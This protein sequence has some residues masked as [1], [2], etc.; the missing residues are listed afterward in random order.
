LYRKNAV[1]DDGASATLI[2]ARYDP[3]RYRVVERISPP[4]SFPAGSFTARKPSTA[5]MLAGSIVPWPN[6]R[7]L[8]THW[9]A[10]R[11]VNSSRK[12]TERAAPATATP[13]PP[14]RRPL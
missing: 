1:T 2:R 13:N 10:S 6:G 3:Y 5:A 9:R 8:L 4:S 7:L 12:S 11:V 14:S